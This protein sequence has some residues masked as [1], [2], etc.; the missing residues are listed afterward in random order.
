M[1][2]RSMSNKHPHIKIQEKNTFINTKITYGELLNTVNKS[3][4]NLKEIEFTDEFTALQMHYNDNYL[5]REL[6]FIL[7]YYNISKRKK[8]KHNIANDITL[9][10]LD[11]ANKELVNKRKLLWFYLDEINNDNYLS[12]FLI[13]D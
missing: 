2:T 6:E 1:E 4:D 5:K 8:N 3:Y 13:L 10:E 12:K 11:D 7:G 9:F